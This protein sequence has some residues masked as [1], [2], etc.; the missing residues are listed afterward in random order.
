MSLK[1]ELILT[2]QATLQGSQYMTIGVDDFGL[3]VDFPLDSA[4]A[5]GDVLY[6]T[7]S[8]AGATDI[9]MVE[10]QPDPAGPYC[11]KINNG[12]DA[13]Y[14]GVQAGR[15][16]TIERRTGETLFGD[17]VGTDSTGIW[18]A[19]P[20]PRTGGVTYTAGLAYT[21]YPIEV[22]PAGGAIRYKRWREAI[23]RSA[24]PASVAY[25]GG[26]LTFTLTSTH[27]GGGHTGGGAWAAHGTLGRRCVVYR[28][29]PSTAGS[30]AVVVGEA[31]SDGTNVTLVVTHTMGQGVTPSTVAADYVV[32]VLGLT[33]LPALAVA[34]GQLDG[35]W[36]LC[37]AIGGVV[38]VSGVQSH[39]YRPQEL[40]DGVAALNA[41]MD[42]RVDRLEGRT[43][44]QDG[45][46]L[47]CYLGTDDHYRLYPTVTDEAGT[48]LLT[49][50]DPA[51][52][53]ALFWFRTGNLLGTTTYRSRTWAA[54]LEAGVVGASGLTVRFADGL[55]SGTKYVVLA[56]DLVGGLG[57]PVLSLVLTAAPAAY[58]IRLFRFTYTSGG[59]PGGIA[60][61]EALDLYPLRGDHPGNVGAVGSVADG[62]ELG[63]IDLV[64]YPP[65]AA[66]AFLA[67]GASQ[68]PRSLLRSTEVAGGLLRKLRT[69]LH[70]FAEDQ[71]TDPEE[72]ASAVFQIE[73]N[74][75]VETRTFR[76]LGPGGL[77]HGVEDA[78][79][80]YLQLGSGMV[81]ECRQAS[82]ALGG[83][84]A[85]RVVDTI[86]DNH[87]LLL[88]DDEGGATSDTTDD[89]PTPGAGQKWLVTLGQGV[90]LALSGNGKIITR[91]VIPTGQCF[92]PGDEWAFDKT[93]GRWDDAATAGDLWVPI[94]CP[95]VARIARVVVD[96]DSV[97]GSGIHTLAAEVFLVDPADAD[98]LGAGTTSVSTP[99]EWDTGE[100][101]ERE[102]EADGDLD[103]DNIPVGFTPSG[104]QQ[105]Y[106]RLRTVHG[107][108]PCTFVLRRVLV[109]YRVYTFSA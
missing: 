35:Y 40:Y 53:E 33:I 8:T 55:S 1:D 89:D 36:L 86:G 57:L 91:N 27:F 95:S 71:P 97:G 66:G 15:I 101:G 41:A 31:L 5:L 98:P 16:L 39:A 3:A 34:A 64:F 105:V 47:G 78:E 19:C 106:L 67:V 92:S 100:S 11:L 25:G 82:T 56:A 13:T 65:T 81:L 88:L 46:R 49:L 12:G 73:S 79:R 29:S 103:I 84:T 68:S 20:Y 93:T 44:N 83:R 74:F 6:P 30:Q 14:D 50:T 45:M 51:T 59:G 2:G 96:A 42:D 107:G 48:V 43:I 58:H 90:D 17:E 4:H 109:L 9:P 70:H 102:V 18:D 85:L 22:V 69:T 24:A 108:D 61:L 99:E 75:D 7:A 54:S 87:S 104:T 26:N 94:P 77:D 32:V 80:L 37:T 62:E 72:D 10:H 76:L 63:V 38:T 21:R 60:D 28:V 52:W 23:G